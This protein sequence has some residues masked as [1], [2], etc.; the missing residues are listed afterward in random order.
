MAQG[1][2][3][4]AHNTQENS[5]FL[6]GLLYR[7]SKQDFFAGWVH[8]FW[9]LFWSVSAASISAQEGARQRCN[10]FAQL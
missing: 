5:A 8:G 9:S 7:Q 4:A 2:I 10:C 1:F 6:G 3:V